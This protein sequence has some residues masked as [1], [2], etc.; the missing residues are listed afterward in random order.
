MKLKVLSVAVICLALGGVLVNQQ[1]TQKQASQKQASEKQADV[2]VSEQSVAASQQGY[3]QAESAVNTVNTAAK[4]IQVEDVKP[5]DSLAAL[6]SDERVP[7]ESYFESVTFNQ[8]SKEERADPKKMLAFEKREQTNLL[9]NFIGVIDKEV[10]LFKATLASQE[11]RQE[12]S[13][14]ASKVAEAEQPLLAEAKDRLS[15]LELLHIDLSA[16]LAEMQSQVM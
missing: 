3:Q 14:E 13:Q 6:L 10:K 5:V 7:V 12:A 9:T 4:A 16:E 11:A 15:Q 1:S 2:T 8:P